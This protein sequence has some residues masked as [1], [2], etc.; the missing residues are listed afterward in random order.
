[1]ANNKPK[2][3]NRQL[4]R[5][6]QKR[7]EVFEGEKARLEAQGYT[8][9]M[10]GVSIIKANLL[11]L[12]VFV[13]LCIFSFM[14]YASLH[15][16]DGSL[17]FNFNI[18]YSMAILPLF[19]V[20]AVVH[21]LIHGTTWAIFAKSGFKSID[22]GVIWHMLTPYC[23]CSEVLGKRAYVAGAMAPTVILG[24]IPYF[25]FLLSGISAFGMFVSL[26]MILCGG[27]DILMTIKLLRFKAP[28]DKKVMFMDH[29]YE[30]GMVAFVSP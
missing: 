18:F 22:Y 19:L 4:S 27:G 6:E 7:K 12:A 14:A 28:S 25:I 26:I 17:H 11:P 29:P 2:K 1:M 23:T 3:P 20:L 24:V 15:M 5:A 16:M 13:P 9:H 30:I 21:E 10:L 8:S